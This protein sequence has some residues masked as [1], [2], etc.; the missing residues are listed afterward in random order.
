MYAETA[1][2]VLGSTEPLAYWWTGEGSLTF[3][4]GH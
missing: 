2:F 4:Q 1:P 3:K